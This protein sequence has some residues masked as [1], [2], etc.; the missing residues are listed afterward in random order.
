[1]ASVASLSFLT[2]TEARAQNNEAIAESLFH[3]GK[4][5]YNEKRY[6]EACQRLDQSHRADPAGG[7]VLLL[8]MCYERLGRTSSA[9]AKYSEALALARRDG[10][11]DR[12]QKA[13]EAMATLEPQLTYV[14]VTLE[15]EAKSIPNM[16]FELDGTHIPLLVDAKVPV[17]P[18]EH[19]LVVKA[20]DYEP[21]T[22]QFSVTDQGAT[23][24]VSVPGLKH[25]EKVVSPVAPVPTPATNADHRPV[26]QPPQLEP[27]SNATRTFAYVLG[28]AGIV[29]AGVGG[30]FA[31]HAKRLD[32]DADERC[33]DRQC[34]DSTAVKWSKDAVSEAKLASWLA[35]AGGAAIVTAGALLI[36][37]G[38]SSPNVAASAI[39]L[40]SGGVL[41]LSGRY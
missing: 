18:G 26:T 12:E 33:P 7:T 27:K 13:Q 23:V 8:A 14:S 9:W 21:F 37:G 17:D 15:L 28:S 1:L 34:D 2:P 22:H 29:A 31:W 40:P 20:T 5:L 38:S 30:Y 35:G 16:E 11:S 36:F 6:A 4:R 41:S 32:N 19:T 25:V 39:V 10:R 3:E 24:S